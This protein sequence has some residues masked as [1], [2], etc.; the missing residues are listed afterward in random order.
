MHRLGS[1]TAPLLLIALAIAVVA[2]EP[3]QKHAGKIVVARTMLPA[4]LLF[5]VA[6]AQG[7]FAAERVEVEERTFVSGRDALEAVISGEADLA[8]P[9]DT[10]TAMRALQGHPLKALTTLHHGRGLSA[11]VARRSSR[12]ETAADLRGK[13]IGVTSGTNV[14]FVLSVLLGSQGLSERDVELIDRHPGDLVGPLLRREVDAAVLWAPDLFEAQRKLGAA[15]VTL[16]LPGYTE[17]CLLVG[18]EPKM[19]E[20]EPQILAL[21]TA[22]HRAEVY[23]QAHPDAA[24]STLRAQFPSLADDD[25]HRVVSQIRFELSVSRVMLSILR[26]Q[27]VWIEGSG[28]ARAPGVTMRAIPFPTYLEHVVPEAVT[29]FDQPMDAALP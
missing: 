16:E 10:A 1:M 2:C 27:A 5:D 17:H 8:T 13:R 3:Q 22:L 9:Y 15:G 19:K 25:V 4:T 29:L 18:L 12:I 26:Q 20:R 24:F 7:F 6:A 21:L 23:I 14:A 28:V 11:L